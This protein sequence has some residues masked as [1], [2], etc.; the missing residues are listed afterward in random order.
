[1]IILAR[2]AAMLIQ[3]AISRSRIMRLMLAAPGSPGTAWPGRRALRKID[4]VA[5]R[6]L[7]DA[8]PATAH[9]LIIAVHG[10]VPHVAFS[11]HPP[12]EDRIR[13][14][15]RR[16]PLE[17]SRPLM[18]PR[19]DSVL[20]LVWPCNATLHAAPGYFLFP[21]NQLESGSTTRR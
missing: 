21:V 5:K 19:Q 8:N 2:L 18:P 11:S 14:L 7:L 13:A 12:T 3:M 6:V 20:T 10:A 15:L 1:M 16:H 9:M 4:A 17:I